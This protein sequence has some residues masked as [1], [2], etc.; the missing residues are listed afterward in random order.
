[1]KT[2]IVATVILAVSAV[3]AF[4]DPSMTTSHLA[5]KRLLDGSTYNG[6]S[7]DFSYL[8]SEGDTYVLGMHGF[9]DIQLVSLPPFLR[10]VPT[11]YGRLIRGTPQPGTYV[12]EM[13]QDGILVPS[14]EMTMRFIP[15]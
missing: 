11:E 8:P 1:M 3:S 9:P 2:S 13:Y 5:P 12:V 4:A 15:R 14:L 7:Y 10:E 6:W